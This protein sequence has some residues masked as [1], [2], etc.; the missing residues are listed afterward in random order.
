MDFRLLGPLEVESGGQLV[1]I[2]GAKERALLALLLFRANRLVSRDL[3]IDELWGERPP[4]TARHTLEA[5]VSRLR[6]ALAAGGN[7]ALLE[8]QSGGYRICVE[9]DQLDVLQFER[10]LEEGRSALASGAPEEAEEKLA[11]A[12]ALW[13]GPVL[14]D[15][16]FEPFAEAEAEARRLEELRLAGVEARLE[17]ALAL[18]RDAELVGELQALVAEHPLRERLRAQLMLALYRSGRQADALAV[19]R[20]GR[21]LLVDELGIE[22]SRKLQELERAILRQEPQLQSP[23]PAPEAMPAAPPR[24][25][26]RARPALARPGLLVAAAAGAAIVV[27][28]AIVVVGERGG[29]GE[30]R[31]AQD[32]VAW[33]DPAGGRM[34]RA[35]VTSTGSAPRGVA[36]GDGAVWTLD[37]VEGLAL[38][39][40]RRSGAVVQTL[41]IGTDAGGVAVG[42]GSAWVTSSSD[43]SVVR[44][45]LK[46]NEIVQRIP[47]GN[48]PTG[49][50]YGFGSVWVAAAGERT[51]A[52][53]GARTGR[54]TARVPT[55]FPGTGVAVGA[56]FVWTTH[57]SAASVSQIDPQTNEVVRTIPVGNGPTAIAAAGGAVWVANSLDGTASRLDPRTGTVTATVAVG[58][59]PVGIASAGDSVWVA[60]EASATL[61]GVDAKTARLIRT[62]PLGAEPRGLAAAGGLLAVPVRATAGDHRGGVLRVAKAEWFDSIDPALAY[63]TASWE[64]LSLT[65]DGLVSFRR[66]GGPEGATLVP[67]LAEALPTGTA[68]RTTYTFRLRPQLRYSTGERV[69]ASDVRRSLERLFRLRSPRLDFYTGLVG[70]AG[71]LA[72]PARCDLSRGVRTNDVTRTVTFHLARPDP[73]FLYKLALPLASLLP[74]ST[75]MRPADAR[76][77][78]ATG[79][80]LLRHYRSAGGGASFELVRNPMFHPYSSRPAGYPDRIVFTHVA[81]RPRPLARAVHLVQLGRLDIAEPL[82][83]ENLAELRARYTSRLHLVQQPGTIFVLLN[84]QRPPFDRLAVR[85]ALNYAAD[86]PAASRSPTAEPTCQLL[87]PSFPAYRPYC[88]YTL[89]AGPGWRGPDLRRARELVDETGT[90][91]MRVT[92]WMGEGWPTD[93]A[94]AVVVR[95]LRRLGYHADGRVVPTQTIHARRHRIQAAVWGWIADYPTPSTFFTV[96]RCQTGGEAL[97]CASGLER[98]ITR[99]T[100]L[101]A[102]NPARA[103]TEWAA[104][105][106]QVVDRALA[107]PLYNPRGYIFVSDRVRNF[108]DHLVYSTLLEQVRVR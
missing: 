12:L 24:P 10:L 79:P 70:G 28:V 51:V 65:N 42:G 86:R 5:Y 84:L 19:Y 36:A 55:G 46:T 37:A 54:R 3:L 16:A 30:I 11:A 105:D 52:R 14:A 18:G 33:L 41:R 66:V 101:Q 47:V 76:P 97:S 72:R 73:E 40:D 13:R 45:D 102:T 78:A 43:A 2:R 75:P 103:D 92:V 49:I 82:L 91:G 23:A 56:G 35:S 67:G 1:R 69:R 106:R 87:P 8:S 62:V 98:T 80:Y 15:L 68:S 21:R 74:P 81:P 53:L 25:L 93:R 58:Q 29:L 38:R 32:G 85:R 104:L 99:L 26:P 44:I 94:L 34:V 77:L 60:N 100:E 48:S 57:A 39:L 4:A 83:G 50:A 71:C 63:T 20:D 27:A 22:P 95:A 108:Q 64:M 9:G 89:G 90:R 61:V 31:I 107:V 7:G 17:A 96:L 88:P 59:E 6:R